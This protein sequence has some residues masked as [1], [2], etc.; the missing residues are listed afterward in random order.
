MNASAVPIEYN[1]HLYE[2]VNADSGGPTGEPTVRNWAT[3]QA[4]AQALGAGWNLVTINDGDENDWLV[5]T[6]QPLVGAGGVA[7]F[8]GLQQEQGANGKDLGWSWVSG[9]AAAYRNWNAD[10]P[11]DGDA[12]RLY[13][14]G[15]EQFGALYLTTTIGGFER[16]AGTWNDLGDKSKSDNMYRYGIAEYAGTAV[17]DPASTMLLL[18]FG[19]S[20]LAVFARGRVRK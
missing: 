16:W 3:A 10:E 14:N 19:L 11:N 9:E 5:R 6:F 12:A 8:I 2:L 13:E 18:G 20:G 15:V 17:P 4:S 7:A 1:G